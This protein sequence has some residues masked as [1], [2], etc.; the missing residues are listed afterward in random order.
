MS[1]RRKGGRHGG[2]KQGGRSQPQQQQSS[3]SPFH[4]LIKDLLYQGFRKVIKRGPT[5]QEAAIGV[6]ATEKAVEQIIKAP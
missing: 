3:D 5:S 2:R 4:L 1:R 6:K